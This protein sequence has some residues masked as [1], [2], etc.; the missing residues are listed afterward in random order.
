[1][2]TRQKLSPS[3]NQLQVS[4]THMAFT[5]NDDVILDQNSKLVA[6]SNDAFGHFDV[7]Y[8]RRWIA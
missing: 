2:Q 5:G 3:S 4:E 6:R 8:G 7:G 1:M